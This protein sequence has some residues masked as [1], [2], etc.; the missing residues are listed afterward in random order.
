MKD[1]LQKIQ[2]L[3]VQFRPKY[4]DV[5]CTGLVKVSTYKDAAGPKVGQADEILL[6]TQCLSPEEIICSRHLLSKTKGA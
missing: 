4:I 6:P 2:E 3:K 5:L 1:I